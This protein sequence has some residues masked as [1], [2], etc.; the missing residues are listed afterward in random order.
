MVV[1]H[2]KAGVVE[3]G[4]WCYERGLVVGTAG[5]LSCR[6]STDGGASNSTVLITATGAHLGHLESADIVEV[7]LHGETVGTVPSE[8]T[9]VERQRNPTSELQLHLNLYHL[10]KGITAVVHTHSPAACAFACSG[11]ELPLLTP[12]AKQHLGRRARVPYRRAGSTELAQLTADAAAELIATRHSTPEVGGAVLLEQHGVVGWGDSLQAAFDSVE[13]VEQA[14][15]TA[16][17]HRQLRTGADQVPQ[18]RRY[19]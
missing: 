17:L 7:L 15:K 5:N 14:A 13:L 3:C 12:E 10:E 2:D 19:P 1:G 6:P 11:R 9:A 4:R 16:I 8:E 18:S